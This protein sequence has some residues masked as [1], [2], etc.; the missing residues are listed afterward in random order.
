M[1][2]KRDPLTDAQIQAFRKLFTRFDR[3]NDGLLA[4]RQA[5]ILMRAVGLDLSRAQ[6]DEVLLGA[7]SN[8]NLALNWREFLDAARIAATPPEPPPGAEP[9][10]PILAEDAFDLPMDEED[11]TELEMRPN[12]NNAAVTR[13]FEVVDTNSDGYIDLLE[14]EAMMI[15]LGSAPTPD[16]VRELMRTVDM[17]GDGRI[18]LAEFSKYYL[19]Q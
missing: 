14:L 13:A 5:D 6:A 17:D 19:R 12:A 3:D 7:D 16:E 10:P 18:N 11:A 2:D 9:E 8:F 4:Y 1:P 15:R